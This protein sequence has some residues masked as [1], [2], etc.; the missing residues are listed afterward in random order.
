MRSK[1]LVACWATALA[2]P[3]AACALVLTGPDAAQIT[4]SGHTG[5][6]LL[7]CLLLT[8]TIKALITCL[9]PKKST[10]A[11]AASGSP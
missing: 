4:T 8:Y 1:G 2:V 10:S 11:G 6:L 7:W 9:T 3:A 5:T